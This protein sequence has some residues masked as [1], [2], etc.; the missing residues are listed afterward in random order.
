M[1][2][3]SFSRILGIHCPVALVVVPQRVGSVSGMEGNSN[4]EVAVEVCLTISTSALRHPLCWDRREIG[5]QSDEQFGACCCYHCQPLSFGRCGRAHALIYMQGRVAID[6]TLK[7]VKFACNA[8]E[9]SVTNHLRVKV[10]DSYRF[11]FFDCIALLWSTCFTNSSGLGRTFLTSQSTTLT[12]YIP[13]NSSQ[14]LQN[15]SSESTTH[16]S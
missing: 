7:G 16:R 1:L 15:F 13:S 3:G 6:W 4:L 9:L 10:L 8:G 11:S 5:G 12:R 2:T 14:N